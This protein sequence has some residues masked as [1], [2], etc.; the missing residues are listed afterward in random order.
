M[1]PRR[2]ALLFMGCVLAVVLA[3]PAIASAC[4]DTPVL[5]QACQAGQAGLGAA[6]LVK[7]NAI[8]G[9][10]PG[11]RNDEPVTN[12]VGD[13]AKGVVGAVA[14]PIFDQI[15]AVTTDAATWL[16]G[17]ITDLID[18]TTSPDLLSAAFVAQYRQMA[19]IA[20]LLAAAMLLMAV[21]EGI[22]R[23][24]LGMLGRAVAINLP[25]AFIATSVAY[26]VVALLIGVTDQLSHAVA[27]STGDNTH[28]FL[29]GA[30]EGLSKAGAAGG[31]VA[32]PIGASAGATSVPVFVVIIAALLSIVAGFFVWIE[33]VMRDAAVYVVALFLPMA[34]AASIWPRW[35]GALRRTAEL[36]MAVIGSKF[37]IVSIIALAAGLL[38]KNEGRF[39]HVIAAAALLLLACFAPV[40]LLRL[41]PFAEG[42]MASAY[43][44]RSGAGAVLSGTQLASSVQLMR[45][46]AQSNLRGGGTAGGGSPGDPRGG[47]PGGGGGGRDA[48]SGGKSGEGEGL[49]SS[50]VSTVGAPIAAG[51]AIAGAGSSAASR[52]ESTAAS[53]EAGAQG[54]VRRPAERGH[55]N[56]PS[57]LDTDRSGEPSGG[58]TH[59]ASEQPPRPPADATSVDAG[60][61][62]K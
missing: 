55:Q 44:R 14:Q 16:I 35:S 26:V 61:R 43:S 42:A 54:E 47:R 2:A 50:A 46:T 27:Q 21:L 25:L 9:P 15:A 11:A 41:V 8:D 48:G 30:S 51:R 62:S 38:A 49:E 31:S 45:S 28:Q 58:S 3:L 19:G 36:L 23:G 57:P 60:E 20:A 6:D 53:S 12:I 13:A 4:T 56:T 1:S 34:L 24:D 59:S 5:S 18:T 17:K 32:G 39:E 10:F 52:L 29:H 7:E 33:L 22:A 40:V 37:V